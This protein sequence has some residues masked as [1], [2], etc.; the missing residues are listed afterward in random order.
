MA[1]MDV[2]G[3]MGVSVVEDCRAAVDARSHAVVVV[4]GHDHPRTIAPQIGAQERGDVEGE[5]RPGAARAV[6]C[7]GVRGGGIGRLEKT[8]RDHA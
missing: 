5:P 2:D 6:L 3:H 8:A 1:S 7:P 4:A